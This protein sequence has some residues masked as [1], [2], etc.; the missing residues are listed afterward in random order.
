MKKKNSNIEKQKDINAAVFGIQIRMFLGLLNADPDPLVRGM[1]P[2][3]AT[4]SSLFS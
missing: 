1:D 3:P 4:D 2:D